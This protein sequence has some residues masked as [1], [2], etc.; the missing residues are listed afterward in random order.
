MDGYHCN[1][2]G[3]HCH[4]I[5]GLT[6]PLNSEVGLFRVNGLLVK[7]IFVTVMERIVWEINFQYERNMCFIIPDGSTTL[8]EYKNI[9]GRKLRKENVLMILCG[10]NEEA[11]NYAK[12]GSW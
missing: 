9:E 12:K 8:R 1:H 11:T 7:I 2:S 10:V 5:T 4:I 3:C 6:S